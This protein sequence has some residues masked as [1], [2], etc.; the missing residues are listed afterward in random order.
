MKKLIIVACMGFLLSA[1]ATLPEKKDEPL[2]EYVRENPVKDIKKRRED[3]YTQKLNALKYRNPVQEAQQAIAARQYY[4]LAY[5]G[6]RGSP[7]K[8]PGLSSSQAANSR[9]SFKRLDGF[10]DSIYG[11]NHLKYRI[12]LRKFARQF[13]QRMF[14]YCR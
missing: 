5:E 12:A 9:C 13:N 10:G 1:C 7:T 6:G 14:A 2:R 11:V 3:E 4:L 8:A